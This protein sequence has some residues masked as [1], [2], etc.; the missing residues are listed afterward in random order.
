MK[1]SPLIAIAAALIMFAISAIAN[2]SE[3]QHNGK[4]VSKGEAIEILIKNPKA[5]VLKIDRV[6]FD[7]DKGTIRNAPK[8]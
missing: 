8:K 2:A 4:I 7:K 3:F 6:I 1:R 5:E